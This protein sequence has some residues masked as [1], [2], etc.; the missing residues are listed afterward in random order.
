MEPRTTESTWLSDVGSRLSALVTSA[1]PHAGRSNALGIYNTFG[2]I[3]KFTFMGAAM[4]ALA[5][6]VTWQATVA[7]FGITALVIAAFAWLT[8]GAVD[9]RFA[10]RPA[11]RQRGNWGIRN[12]RGFTALGV[13]ASLDAAGRVAFLTFVAFLMMEKGVPA[14]WAAA[15][16]LVTLFGGMCGKF[17]CGRLAERVGVIATITITEVWTALGIV[18]VV[19]LPAEAAF[20]ALPLVGVALNGTSTVIYASVGDLIDED[21]HARAFAVIYTIGSLCGVVAPFGFGLVADAT[22]IVT[23]LLAVAAL[24]GATLLLLPT[25]AAALRPPA[26]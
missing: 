10:A 21:R 13:I 8:V 14:E 22:S 1:F 5:L 15:A 25:L 18:A 16:V 6:G 20:V 12:V 17:A 23:A 26:A 7:G 24:V 3:G 11:P 19:A 9:A 2:D 4:L